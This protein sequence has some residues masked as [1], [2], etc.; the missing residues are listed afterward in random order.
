MKDILRL[1]NPNKINTIKRIEKD[2]KLRYI[3]TQSNKLSFNIGKS[4]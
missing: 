1:L 2:N 4:N 3:I